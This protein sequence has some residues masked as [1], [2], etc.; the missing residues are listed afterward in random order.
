LGGLPLQFTKKLVIDRQSG[1]RH[2]HKHKSSASRCQRP[3]TRRL[4][5]RGRRI[6]GILGEQKGKGVSGR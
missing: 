2:M 1:S 3:Y 6:V 5:M 4:V